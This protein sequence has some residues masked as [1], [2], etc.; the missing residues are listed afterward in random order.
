MHAHIYHTMAT[1]I[2]LAFD[3]YGTLLST[4]SI[5]KQLATHFGQE[6]ADDLAVLWR[7]IQVEYTWR[8]TCMRVSSLVDSSV[9]W[10]D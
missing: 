1:N 10:P 6:K 9:S 3:I 7:R 8:L 5:A 4:G 2:I